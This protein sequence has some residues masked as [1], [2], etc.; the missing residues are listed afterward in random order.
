[1][2]VIKILLAIIVVILLS[3]IVFLLRWIDPE[4]SRE[5]DNFEP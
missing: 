4:G 2:T 5:I 1:M 3:P